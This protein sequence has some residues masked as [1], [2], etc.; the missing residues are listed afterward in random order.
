MTAAIVVLFHPDQRAVERLLSSLKGQ[1]D[2]VFALDNTPGSSLP[3]PEFYD[4]FT[5]FVSY[6]PLGENKGVAEAQNI[7][8]DLSIKNEHSHVLLLDQDSA[9]SPGMV[10]KLLAAEEKLLSRGERVAA[11]TPQIMDERTGARPC[12]IRYRWFSVRKVFCDVSATEPVQT[13]YFIASGSLIRTSVLQ[14]LGKMRSDLFIE[15]VDTEWALRGHTAGYNSYCVPDAALM[16]SF[17]DAALKLFGKDL[18]LYTD[19][20]YYYKLR[21]EA[22]LALRQT[23]GA[24]WRTYILTRLPYHFLLYA[25]LSRNRVRAFRLFAQAILDGMLGKLGPIK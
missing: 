24:Q 12:A 16:H 7:G 20:R 3:K 1:V 2:A 4:G 22:H 25:A 10:N 23:M 9:A 11:M 8:I 21:N 17:G 18:F 5:D 6:I 14:I 13:D 15:H 19:L